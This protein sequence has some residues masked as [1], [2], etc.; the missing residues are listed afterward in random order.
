MKPLC[1]LLLALAL[2]LSSPAWARLDWSALEQYQ[3]QQRLLYFEAASPA[4]AG[5]LLVWPEQDRQHDWLAMAQ[6]WQQRGWDFILLLPEPAQHSLDPA[7][8]QATP[9]QQAWL[10]RL[11]ERLGQVLADTE[12][13]PP[14]LVLTQGSATPWY[15]QLVEAGRRPPPDALVVLDAS[16]AGYARQQMLAMSLARSDYPVLDIYSHPHDPASRLNRLRRQHQATQREKNDYSQQHLQGHALLERHITAWLVRLGWL[17][18]PPGA[19]DYL[20]G[21]IH[22]TGISRSTDTGAGD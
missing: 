11:G 13:A 4:L 17:A 22:E 5:T 2:L 15:Q 10:D 8:E 19:P 16:P 21:R 12:S 7:T 3:P 18:P 14:L 1:R 9:A 6:Y 20:K